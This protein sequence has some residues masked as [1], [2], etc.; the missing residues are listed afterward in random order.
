MRSSSC[1]CGCQA[2]AADSA[3]QQQRHNNP[4]ERRLDRLLRAALIVQVAGLA[5]LKACAQPLADHYQ[6][7]FGDSASRLSADEMAA[8]FA[9][10]S[11][12]LTVSADGR[13]LEDPNCGDIMP[14]VEVVD[15]RDP[16]AGYQRQFGFPAINWEPLVIG[17]DG[18]PDLMFG[19]PGFCHPV[20]TFR[21]GAYPF[22]CSR[23]DSL[24]G[25]ALRNDVCAVE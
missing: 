24:D 21:A 11:D 15:L 22:K 10:F 9:A 20:W 4:K 25:C 5:P 17:E 12:G 3:A 8:P 13:R 14:S 19:G 6:I 1:N 18:W 2:A 7:L 23:P 16:A